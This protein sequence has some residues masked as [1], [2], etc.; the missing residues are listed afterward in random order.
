MVVN[1]SS[2]AALGTSENP[3]GALKLEEERR[4]LELVNNHR[5]VVVARAWSVSGPLVV[6]PDRYL[7]SSLIVQAL[8][9]VV[10]VHSE[11]EVWRRYIG[12]DDLLAVAIADAASNRSGVLDSG[13]PLVEAG[14]LAHRIADLADATV[15]SRTLD[16][17]LPPDFYAS[18]NEDWIAS[19]R[20]HSYVPADLDEQILRVLSGF[21]HY[22]KFS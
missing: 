12:V 2:G 8:S 16:S 6:R 21:S 14:K 20:F 22:A 13:G 10:S 4:A 15:S 11:K 1:I 3:Y 5:S 19:T 18:N 7:F 17:S 9:G